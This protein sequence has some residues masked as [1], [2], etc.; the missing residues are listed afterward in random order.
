MPFPGGCGQRLKRSLGK[1]CLSC[2]ENVPQNDGIGQSMQ[3]NAF[4]LGNSFQTTQASF[5]EGAF[6]SLPT[7]SRKRLPDG[8]LSSAATPES[9]QFVRTA[10]VHNPYTMQTTICQ[11]SRLKEYQKR[12]RLSD[13]NAAGLPKGH[14][15]GKRAHIDII[16]AAAQGLRL[17]RPD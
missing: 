4:I 11:S 10:R 17:A 5:P 12:A 13:E 9:S 15:L 14:N 6:Q 7:S 1:A 3:I 16:H 2:L 8:D